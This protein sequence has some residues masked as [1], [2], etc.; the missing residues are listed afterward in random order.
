MNIPVK[1]V[2]LNNGYLG[3]VRQWQELFFEHRYSETHLEDGNPDFVMV[4]KGFGVEAFR[5][6]QPGELH[7]TLARAFAHP[8][9]VLV[10][11]VTA[12]QELAMPPKIRLEQAKGFSLF[13]L[14]A[15][16]SGRGDEVVELAKTNLFR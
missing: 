10:D 4:A 15:I 12:K 2:I 3:M 8:G 11:V 16:I 14:K 7:A 5:V 6:T 13:M 9:P 1:I